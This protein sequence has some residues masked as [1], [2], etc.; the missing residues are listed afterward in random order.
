MRG[1]TPSSSAL[2]TET[3]T[4]LANRDT[5]RV[6]IYGEPSYFGN[7]AVLADD[8]I[9]VNADMISTSG[10]IYLDGDMEDEAS[11]NEC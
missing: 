4:L 8:G 10:F 1:L 3:I 5:T 9:Q 11:S 2:I 6:L 7:L